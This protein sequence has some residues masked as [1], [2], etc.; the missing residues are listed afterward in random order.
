MRKKWRTSTQ[1]EKEERKLD[2]DNTDVVDGDDK[3][4]D[5]LFLLET[6]SPAVL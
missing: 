5:H 4:Q 3:L 6:A 2:K 1:R